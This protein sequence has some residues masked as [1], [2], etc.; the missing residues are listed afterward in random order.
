LRDNALDDVEKL[1]VSAGHLRD[2]KD[3]S[4]VYRIRTAEIARADLTVL[5]GYRTGGADGNRANDR[6]AAAGSGTR[7]DRGD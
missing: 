3:V 6:V 5:K 1:F 2:N 7:S 4:A